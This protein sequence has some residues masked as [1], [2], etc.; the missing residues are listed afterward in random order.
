[1]KLK[2][3]NLILSSLVI[4]LTISSLEVK[5]ESWDKKFYDRK[6]IDGTVVL[7]MPCDGAMAFRV[8][9]TN[10]KSP[11][12]DN[13]IVLGNESGEQ[14]YAEHS[15]PT[16]IAGSFDENGERYFL[17]GKYEVTTDQYNVVMNGGNCVSPTMKGLMPITNISWFD[18]IAFS[19]KYNE[20]LMKNHQDKLPKEDGHFGFVRLP[21]NTEWEYATRGGA[22]VSESEFR[23]KVFPTPEGIKSVAFGAN[24]SNG[25]IQLV[26][27]VTKPNPLGIFD[28]L[29]N[30]SEMMF[31]TFKLNKLDRYHGQNGGITVRGG[32]YLTPEDQLS[33]SYR[34]ELPFYTNSGEASK[35]KDMGFRLVVVS[36]IITS[37]ARIKELEAEWQKLG[38]DSNSKDR[39]IVDNLAKISAG[40]ENKEM[41]KQLKLLEDALRS[42]NQAK[43]EQRDKAIQSAIQL[44][45]FLCSNTADLHQTYLNA[46]NH[47]DSFCSLETANK[48]N[49]ALFKAKEE[50][51]KDVRD[52]TLKYYADTLVE[53]ATIYHQ[54]TIKNQ[55]LPVLN[56]LKNQRKSNSD[57]F[58]GIYWDHLQSF[59]A[60][61]KVDRDN[62]LQSC[63]KTLE[64]K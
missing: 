1:M 38:K 54:E 8:V 47:N 51:Y 16:Y 40:A 31:D 13:A 10:T 17:I 27:Q 9:K 55:V 57:L 6:E 37:S 23:E 35:A 53:T 14:S 11:L 46:K 5:A 45:A 15:T 60:N 3:F 36:P 49:C 20:W 22:V 52:F 21:T 12:E 33:S 30:A 50:S 42:S 28:T 58:V 63:I 18:A 4:Y 48:E 7:P 56:K 59:Y 24:A 32:S 43:D 64:Q 41:K 62:W 34:I 26:G 39:E 44:G 29:G 25:R 2:P 61:G 19:N